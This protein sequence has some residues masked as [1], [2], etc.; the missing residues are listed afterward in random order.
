MCWKHTSCTCTVLCAWSLDNG[1]SFTFM[2]CTD[3]FFSSHQTWSCIS[4]SHKGS[5]LVW[6]MQ[7]IN[8]TF[9]FRGSNIVHPGY[10]WCKFK[11][12]FVNWTVF[13]LYI[14]N[15]SYFLIKTWH[16]LHWWMLALNPNQQLICSHGPFHDGWNK[17]G[18]VVLVPLPCSLGSP[19]SLNNR[20]WQHSGW[21]PVFDLEESASF[22]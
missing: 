8:H 14:Q 9:L 4:S 13:Q 15:F 2:Q 19:L 20:V 6:G 3:S 1:S 10:T 11:F 12:S 18:N 7:A 22:S 17:N 21:T 5:S 16:L